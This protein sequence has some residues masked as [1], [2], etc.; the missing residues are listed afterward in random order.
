MRRAR[1]RVHE[2]GPQRPQTTAKATGWHLRR[3]NNCRISGVYHGGYP[4]AYARTV[5]KDPH[6]TAP[7]VR[8]EL[9]RGAQPLTVRVTAETGRTGRTRMV[10]NFA[11]VGPDRHESGSVRDRCYFRAANNRPP[12]TL[13]ICGLIRGLSDS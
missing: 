1:Q 13:L 3:T 11:L 7:E 4:R 10:P 2:I 12:D 8:A 6:P 5:A 9:G